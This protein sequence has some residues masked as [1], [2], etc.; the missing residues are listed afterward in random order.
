[1]GRTTSKLTAKGIESLKEIGRHS[2]GGGLYLKVT[3]FGKRWVFMYT[4]HDKRVE[5]GLGTLGDVSL[6]AAR[7]KAQSYR[8]LLA[9]NI[10]P[11]I[12]RAA[13]DVKPMTFGEFALQFIQTKEG[14][15]KNP[16][17]RDQWYFTLSVR[18]DEKGNFT[19]DGY[20]I[21]LRDLPIAEVTT[22]DVK[23]VLAPIWLTKTETATRLRGRIEAVLDAAKAQEKRQGENP[24]AWRGHLKMILPT[25]K[26]LTR[27]HHAA[28]PYA[29][30][31]AFTQRLIAAP[32][33]SNSALAFTILTAGRSGEI[34]GATWDEIDT[35]EAVWR[36]PASRMKGGREHVVPLSDGALA[37]LSVMES[38]RRDGN[39]FVFPGQRGKGLSVMALSMAMRR[40]GAGDYT[41]HGFR[42][43]FRD[44]AG[45]AT[46]FQRDDI[47][48]C[49]AHAIAN[50]VEA[51][52]R[53]GQALEKRSNIMK[54]WWRYVSGDNSEVSILFPAT[55]TSRA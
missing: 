43:A 45:D 11:R 21:S 54:T 24:A 29:S 5:L 32:T 3:E 9:K 19:K 2:D 7:E 37:I 42:S 39:D 38:F 16:K 26:K 31:P 27:G 49:L 10:D 20:C 17:H 55:I 15:W 47:E 28:M 33:V 23:K 40:L 6:K 1:M 48:Q 46:T 13:D 36:V 35:E 41:P 52:Y 18:K 30:V 53:R 51:A 22:E 12:E 34:L 14:G 8:E 44:W 25:P 4:W 50:K